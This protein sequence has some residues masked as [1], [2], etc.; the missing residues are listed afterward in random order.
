[1]RVALI[2][3]NEDEVIDDAFEDGENVIDDWHDHG[4]DVDEGVIDIKVQ[5]LKEGRPGVVFPAVKNRLPRKIPQL[6]RSKGRN[7]F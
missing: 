1:M 7:G 3:R 2:A 5:N 6:R 4:E